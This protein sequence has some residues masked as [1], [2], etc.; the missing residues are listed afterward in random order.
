MEKLYHCHCVSWQENMP[1]IDGVFGL[2]H[3]HRV[4]YDGAEFEYC[5]WCGKLLESDTHEL[6][7]DEYLAIYDMP[8]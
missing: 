4:H 7:E 6:S 2:A 3:A 8:R 1:K 5:P